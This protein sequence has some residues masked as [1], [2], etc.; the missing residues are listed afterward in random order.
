MKEPRLPEP[1]EEI[2]QE[3]EMPQVPYISS[4]ARA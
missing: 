3:D 1:L 4:I 2:E